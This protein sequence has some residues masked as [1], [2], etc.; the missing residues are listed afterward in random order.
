MDHDHH[1]SW[2]KPRDTIV[3]LGSITSRGEGTLNGEDQVGTQ[4]DVQHQGQKLEELEEKG[5]RVTH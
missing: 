3:P 2:H 5:I 1:E 4:A